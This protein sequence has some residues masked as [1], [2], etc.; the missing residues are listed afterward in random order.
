MTPL[1]SFSR[2]IDDENIR[3]VIELLV[4]FVVFVVGREIEE[5]V[6]VIVVAIKA[7]LLDET[8]IGV[9]VAVMR[10]AAV[11]KADHTLLV[12]V[13]DESAQSVEIEHTFVASQASQRPVVGVESRLQRQLLLLLVGR[14]SVNIFGLVVLIL[15]ATTFSP[16]PSL[17]LGQL[18]VVQFLRL[19][20]TAHAHHEIILFCMIFS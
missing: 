13:V 9:D 5:L 12:V 18:E 3:C 15:A 7:L 2:L 17:D 19:A 11:E 8:Q 10:R 16:L 6:L 14:S 20:L 4:A 1:V